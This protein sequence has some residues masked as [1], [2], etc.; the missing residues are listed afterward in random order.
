ML[1]QSAVKY[2]LWVPLGWFYSA[3]YLHCMVCGR[4]NNRGAGGPADT[5]PVYA[6]VYGVTTDIYDGKFMYRIEIH[7][8][9]DNT[10]NDG[11]FYFELKNY[12]AWDDHSS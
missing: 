8:A 6:Q 1:M 9:D 11:G 5:G 12:G 4:G 2:F 10:E 7:V 3:D